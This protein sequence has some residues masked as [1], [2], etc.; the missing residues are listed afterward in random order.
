MPKNEMIIIIIV[1]KNSSK[2]HYII[3]AVLDVLVNS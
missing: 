3:N 1:I 2:N